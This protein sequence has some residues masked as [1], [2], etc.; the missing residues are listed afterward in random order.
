M[1]F[2]LVSLNNETV[3]CVKRPFNLNKRKLRILDENGDPLGVIKKHFSLNNASIEI[4]DAEKKQ[5]YGIKCP[6]PPSHW[7]FLKI[8]H[9]TQ[10]VGSIKKKNVLRNSTNA[11]LLETLELNFPQGADNKARALLIGVVLCLDILMCEDV[12][13]E[14][15][16]LKDN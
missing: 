16:H 14:P 6:S 9:E 11:D 7:S 15:R 5:I 2:P 1:S 8:K 4:Y 3:M 10:E 13:S 12:S